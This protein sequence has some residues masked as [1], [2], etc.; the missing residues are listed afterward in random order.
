[1]TSSP[2]PNSKARTLTEEE[3]WELTKNTFFARLAVIENGDVFITPINILPHEGKVYFRT[4]IGSKLLNLHMNQKVTLQFDH[5]DESSAYSVNI[6]GNARLL[7]DHQEIEAAS[8][9]GMVSW[10]KSDKPFIVEITPR[11][12]TGRSFDLT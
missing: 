5:T 8:N 2:Q 11:K 6:L 10:I 4:A 12:Y 7:T 9:L 1:M 3:C